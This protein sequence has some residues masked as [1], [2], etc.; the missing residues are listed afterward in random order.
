MKI[1]L[2][3]LPQALK[4]STPNLYW[5]AGDEFLQKQEAVSLILKTLKTKTPPETETIF[6]TIDKNFD[7]VLLHQAISEP[8]LFSSHQIIKI[9]L[10]DPWPPK[11]TQII[12]DA[13]LN[14]PNTI[15]IIIS[16]SKI[17]QAKQQENGFKILESKI[18]FIQI[19][20]IEPHQLSAWIR[21]KAAQLGLHIHPTA[22]HYLAQSTEGNLLSTYQALEKLAYLGPQEIS[23]SLMESVQSDMTHFDPFNLIDSWFLKDIPKTLRIFNSLLDQEVELT[24][25]LWVLAQEI[26]LLANLHTESQNTPQFDLFKKYK[27][28]EKKKPIIQAG[29]RHFSK[30]TCYDL[31]QKLAQIDRQIKG[32]EPGSAEQSI[33][34][35]FL[36]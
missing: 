8:S 33:Q 22:I 26:R 3:E 16:S 2:R 5:I 9:I 17:P 20:P 1:S 6:L 23:L 15:Q 25:V 10:E 21:D 7:L 13:L 28:Y 35:I 36:C 32:A 29:L 11:F 27:I 4:K 19:W 12:F 24:H 18:L 14:L 30:Q 31:L 34:K